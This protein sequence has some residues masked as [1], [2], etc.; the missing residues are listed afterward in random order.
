MKFIHILLFFT[1]LCFSPM[2]WGQQVDEVTLAKRAERQ[3]LIIKEWNT[4]ARSQTRW[5]DRIT[6]YDAEG[7]K[8]E[9]IEYAP[10]GQK[11]RQTYEYGSHGRIQQEVEYNDRD[12]PVIIRKYEYNEDGSKKRQYNYAP[13]GKLQTIKVFEYVIAE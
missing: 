2:L 7:R 3:N 12:K 5:L 9:Q 6:T 8:I 11:W 4:D 13:N 10:Y 1:L